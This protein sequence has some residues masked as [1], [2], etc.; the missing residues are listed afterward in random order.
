[1]GPDRARPRVLFLDVLGTVVDE[2]GSAAAEFERAVREVTGEPGRGHDLARA[3]LRRSGDLVRS[4]GAGD[5]D[6]APMDEVNYR[7]LIQAAADE[8]IGFPEPVLRTLSRVPGRMRPWPDAVPG[9]RALARRYPVVALSNADLPSLV[10]MA[11]RGGLPWHCVLPSELVRSYKPDPAVYRMALSLLRVEPDEALFV[12]A[13]PWDLRAAAGVGMPTVRVA[14]AGTGEPDP[15]GGF[16]LA[17]DD[18]EELAR[19]VVPADEP[20]AVE[21]TVRGTGGR[22]ACGLVTSRDNRDVRW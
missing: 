7:A 16:A 8:R 21:E 15:G 17:V 13:H 4:I 12:A 10:E 11:R 1:M 6:W 14:R 9:L 19:A 3:W 20:D 18:L 5:E 2:E 22:E